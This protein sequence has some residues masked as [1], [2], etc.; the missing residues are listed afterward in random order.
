[1]RTIESS[2]SAVMEGAECPLVLLVEMQLSETVRMA[3]AP[4]TIT[5][6]GNDYLG[7]GNLG[8]VE[9]VEDSP[10]EYKPLRFNLSAVSTDLLAISLEENIRGQACSVR[11][12][13]LDPVTHQ[14]LDAP[15]AWSGTLD[16]MP[17]TLPRDKNNSF[18]IG[19]TAE[20]RGMTYARPKPL[21]YTDADQRRLYPTD[22][23]LRFI[24]AQSNHAD[25]WPA[26]SFYRV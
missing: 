9:P 20:H 8:T 5:F 6:G 14:V 3:S 26:A 12:A 17:V 18:A 25:A 15:L 13:V 23:S 22:T 10:G 16:Q 4:R 1:M 21:R 11:M 2:A 7:L 24:D 19:A